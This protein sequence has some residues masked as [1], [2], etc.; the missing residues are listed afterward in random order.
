MIGIVFAIGGVHA[1]CAAGS[2]TIFLGMIMNTF[3]TK[4]FV[5]PLIMLG[6]FAACAIADDHVP[7]PGPSAT[8]SSRTDSST[9]SS[10]HDGLTSGAGTATGSASR[11]GMG[12]GGSSTAAGSATQAGSATSIIPFGGDRNRTR[13][14]GINPENDRGGLGTGG[15][16]NGT[17]T[18][19]DRGGLGTGGDN[20]G[21]TS[22]GAFNR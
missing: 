17:G 11:S 9:R 7:K 8:S 22:T 6:G 1:A 12:I 3:A 4:T 14:D 5:L 18:G 16:R 20:R 19:G 15:D 2:F 13:V 21:K 10:L